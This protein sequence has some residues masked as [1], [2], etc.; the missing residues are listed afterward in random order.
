MNTSYYRTLQN[1]ANFAPILA[2][3]EEFITVSEE[4]A[5]QETRKL[6]VE[7]CGLKDQDALAW[8]E[9]V[10]EYRMFVPEVPTNGDGHSTPAEAQATQIIQ[11]DANGEFPTPLDGAIWMVGDVRHPTNAIERR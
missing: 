7:Q 3:Y 5:R 9:T 2:K 8:V 1:D 6:L 10:E 4:A 11:P